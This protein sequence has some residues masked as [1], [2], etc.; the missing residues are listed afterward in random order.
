M[1][2]KVVATSRDEV[3][4][5]TAKGILEA[6]TVFYP[7]QSSGSNQ[8]LRC[9][10]LYRNVQTSEYVCFISHDSVLYVPGAMLQKQS[11][12]RECNDDER[13]WQPLVFIW[14]YSLSY[15]K[16]TDCSNRAFMRP[17]LL[18]IKYYLAFFIG[19]FV[20]FKKANNCNHWVLILP[21]G[22]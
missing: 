10:Q 7:S 12:D 18:W 3:D 13:F 5:L 1:A 22:V 21:V 14:F 2:N 8:R 15:F 20:P 9:G 17:V 11:E 19:K 4:E 16:R 6:E